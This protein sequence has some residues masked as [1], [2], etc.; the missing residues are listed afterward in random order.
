MSDDVASDA[1][2]QTTTGA[3][4]VAD[5]ETGWTASVRR[6]VEKTLP[7]AEL[8]PTKQPAYVGSWVY[9]FGAVSYT[10]LDVYKRQRLTISAQ[11]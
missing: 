9:V 3:E 6:R 7:I 10:H 1:F 4:S 5:D 8:L 2:D 11:A